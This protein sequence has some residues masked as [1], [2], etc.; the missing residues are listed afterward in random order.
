[1]VRFIDEFIKRG[2]SAQCDA[3]AD[4]ELHFQKTPERGHGF[5]NSSWKAQDKIGSRDRN[6][7]FLASLRFRQLTEVL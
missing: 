7:S 6:R 3:D 5:H 4:L 1:M 2:H